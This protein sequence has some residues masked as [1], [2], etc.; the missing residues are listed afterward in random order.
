MGWRAEW[1]IPVGKW[2]DLK[3]GKW[4]GFRDGMGPEPADSEW[5]SMTR[6]NFKTGE[7]ERMGAVLVTIELL[8][9]AIAD[10]RK[11]GEG[12]AEPNMFPFLPAPVGRVKLNMLWNP[13]YVLS[14]CLG[15]KLCRRLCCVCCL[16]VL[17]LV[18]V[19]GMPAITAASDILKAIPSPWGY[20]VGGVAVFFLLLLCFAC[21]RCAR[22]E[23]QQEPPETAKR[24]ARDGAKASDAAAAA[25]VAKDAKKEK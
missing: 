10:T 19:F 20:V 5:I 6:R 18:L 14:E 13:F 3:E 22:S 12:R 7:V 17:I 23:A 8:P 25:S 15:P 21:A 9:K 1:W 2:A 11:N 4:R 24:A 16:I